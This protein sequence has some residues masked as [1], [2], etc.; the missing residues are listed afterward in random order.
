MARG[1]V[2]SVKVDVEDEVVVLARRSVRRPPDR[3]DATVGVVALVRDRDV[4][5]VVAAKL[6]RQAGVVALVV[7]EGGPDGCVH[8]LQRPRKRGLG[9]HQRC[10]LGR[11]RGRL[12]R[13]RCRERPLDGVLERR[14]RGVGEQAGGGLSR[15]DVTS[16]LGDRCMEIR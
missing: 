15:G 14:G 2:H 6:V 1:L 7:G 5:V 4:C 11:G 10:G 16:N 3:D 12:S 8:D 9:G 13:D